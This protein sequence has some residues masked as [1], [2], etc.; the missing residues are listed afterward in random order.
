MARSFNSFN[1]ESRRFQ[2]LRIC[3]LISRGKESPDDINSHRGIYESDFNRKW[4][5][6]Q[7]F[8]GLKF[9]IHGTCYLNPS[10]IGRLG[11]EV[12]PFFMG[13]TYKSFMIPVYAFIF[14]SRDEN[15]DEKVREYLAYENKEDGNVLWKVEPL[16]WY[17]YGRFRSLMEPNALQGS[18]IALVFFQKKSF[19]D[20][21]DISEVFSNMRNSISTLRSKWEVAIIGLLKGNIDGFALLSNKGTNDTQKL[22][23][24][25]ESL[26]S[27]LSQDRQE[28]PFW[29]DTSPVV[30]YYGDSIDPQTDNL[31]FI[32]KF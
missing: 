1:E 15:E 26:S 28:D 22:I 16:S 11:G 6:L 14:L 2:V 32:E 24:A 3:H 25:A 29:H 19:N 31:S 8:C 7:H 18:N 20:L 13:K 9:K 12:I 17:G 30:M 10:D 21:T 27:W 23:D 4:K 5:D